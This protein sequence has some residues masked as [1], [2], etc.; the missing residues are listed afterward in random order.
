MPL[1]AAPNLEGSDVLLP[2]A[3]FQT[4]LV[5]PGVGFQMWIIAGSMYLE[6]G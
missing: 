3:Q 2:R 1:P 6:G 5:P 4:P